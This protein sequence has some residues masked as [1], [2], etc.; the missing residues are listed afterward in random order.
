M[1]VTFRRMEVRVSK[2]IKMETEQS[3]V[4]HLHLGD[5][6]QQLTCLQ[7]QPF[8]QFFHMPPPMP[9]PQYSPYPMPMQHASSMPTFVM[10]APMHLQRDQGR[11]GQGCYGTIQ[12][13]QDNF[14]HYMGQGK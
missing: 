1:M 10:Q 11:G 13:A 14:V 2:K 12:L 8:Q 9:P 4:S 6:K 7:V 5:M 3:E